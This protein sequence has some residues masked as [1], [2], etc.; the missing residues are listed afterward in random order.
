MVIVY[1]VD[2]D[3]PEKDTVVSLISVVMES[4]IAPSDEIVNV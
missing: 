1:C 3:N 2:G 4:L